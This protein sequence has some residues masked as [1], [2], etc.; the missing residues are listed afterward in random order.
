[1]HIEL[2]PIDRLKPYA[3]NPR[4]NDKAVESVARS[5][6][7]FGF[8]QTIVVDEAGVIIV[9]HTR[10]KAAIK[11][12][13]ET[14]PVHVATGLTPAQVKAYRLADNKTAEIADWNY[15]LLPIELSQLRDLDF[16]LGLIGFDQDELAQLLDPGVQEGLTD[17]DEIPAP[18]DAAITQ[19]GDLWLLG[20]HR[21]L[22]GDS[23]KPED[24][25]WLL[26]GAEVHL[27]NTDPPYNVRVEPRS[28]NAIA[29]G[30]SSFQ[31]TTHHQSLDVA[32]HPEKAKPTQKKLRAKDRPLA[33]DFVSN[34]EFDRLLD[35]WFGNI[36]RVL[37]PGRGFYIWG[38]Y[39]NCGN[40]P[41]FLKKHGLY[42]SQAIIWVKEHP[43]LTRKDFMGNH[44]WCQPPDTQVLTPAGAASI[45]SLHD[46]DRV[47]SFSRESSAVVGFRRGFEVRATSRAYD[48]PLYEVVVGNRSTWCTAG[49]HWTVKMT[50]EAASW[51]CV[52]L[53]RRGSWW[54]V[55]KSKLLS[56]WGFGLKQRMF[57]EGGED[58]WILSIHSSNT[59]AA[60]AEQLVATRY[61]I[62]TTFWRESAT[63]QRSAAQIAELYGNLDLR[64]LAHGAFRA[65]DD[66]GRVLDYP[67][68]S[69][70]NTR[71]KYGRRVPLLVRAC[72]LIPGAMAIPVPEKGQR[73][74]WVPVR[75]VDVEPYCGPVY[76]MAV[77]K[78]R[79]Y[80][81]DGLV[82]H[83]C[84][85]GWREGAAHQYLGPNNAT[86][87]WSVKK[88][89]P[90]SM[91]HLTE[92]PVELAVRAMQYS[93]R[94]G[95][96][97]LDLFG[98]SGSTLIAAQQ[99]GRK[100]L[101]MELDPLYCDVIVQRYEQFT[102]QKA[103]RVPAAEPAPAAASSDAA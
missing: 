12:G 34:Q 50:P 101:L 74:S 15:D 18:P 44:E 54:R 21:L 69:H 87:V 65:L 40:Y 8:R 20:D 97:V 11:L 89:N 49:H 14:V 98:G 47:V 38:G 5:L 78:H 6:Q 19:P 67:F 70:G 100:A 66:H 16:D 86:D 91:V 56:T 42:F 48:G 61:G 4:H 99:T 84:F 10:Y 85:Y 23:S 90:Q 68:V 46:G 29:A 83:N 77:E 37:Q 79:H 3:N 63:T 80:I 82:T 59:D 92:K 95:E 27:C 26:D 81:A 75:A 72:N 43:V 28:N 103:E 25:D 62:P 93:S 24:V 102:G 17:P 22:C 52:Y 53:M 57:T 31:G 30:L 76:S 94:A 88:V 7:E 32:R 35:A 36:T 13:L 73:F 58:A 64:E 71:P 55:G 39:A 9:G 41:P 45:R 51:W 60:I 1:M 2:W 33:N 96:N